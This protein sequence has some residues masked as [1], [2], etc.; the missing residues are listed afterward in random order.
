MEWNLRYHPE[1]VAFLGSLPF[2][3][4][5]MA[6]KETQTMYSGKLSKWHPSIQLQC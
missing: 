5:V 6:P 2:N 4:S 3:T 1:E